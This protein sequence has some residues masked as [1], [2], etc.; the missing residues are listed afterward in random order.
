VQAKTQVPDNVELT[1]FPSNGK[2]TL[3]EL[4]YPE[5][6]SLCPI[7]GRHDQGTVRIQ[8]ITDEKIMETKSVRDYLA[9]WRTVRNWQE[10]ITEEIAEKIYRNCG[11]KWLKV[12]IQWAPRGGV[13]SRT[14]AE[15]GKR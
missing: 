2:G 7:S 6:Q 11:P 13:F 9:S 12:E 8:Y 1:T 4:T 10:Y 14:E 3:V 15:R 5:F